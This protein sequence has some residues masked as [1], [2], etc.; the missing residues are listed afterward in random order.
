MFVLE[1]PPKFVE[2]CLE[3]PSQ[4]LH[5]FP[6]NAWAQLIGLQLASICPLCG[7]YQESASSLFFSCSFVHDFW[8]WILL[9]ANAQVP[10]SLSI[11][12]LLQVSQKRF[13]SRLHLCHFQPLES[14]GFYHLQ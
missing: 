14:E 5:K 12:Q 4:A 13:G 10:P 7:A 8:E 9:Q 6:S 11:S 3:Q 2:V 1:A